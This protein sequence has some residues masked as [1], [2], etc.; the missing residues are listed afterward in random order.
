MRGL[1]IKNSVVTNVAIFDE[2]PNGWVLA[3]EGVG[4]GWE[5]NGDG[6]FSAPAPDPIS[7]DKA[8]IIREEYINNQREV[9]MNSGIVYGGN[10]YDSDQ[11]SRDNLTG[12]H[13]GI[14]DGYI[15]P[16]GFTW[17]TSDNKN[18][19]FAAA[20]VNGLAHAMLDHVNTQ[21]GK[22]WSLKSDID[23]AT[24]EAAVNAVIW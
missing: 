10:S 6:T 18:I 21:Y 9:A 17:R 16:V 12:I 19:P 11:R 7:L 3:P 15:L 2:I 4:I 20:E 1:Q 24:D 8:K 23:T 13:T 14:N 5:D 22:S